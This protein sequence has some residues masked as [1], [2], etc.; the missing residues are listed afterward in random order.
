LFSAVSTE[1]EEKFGSHDVDFELISFDNGKKF[2]L[3][4]RTGRESPEGE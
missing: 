4:V 1:F 3:R 2:P